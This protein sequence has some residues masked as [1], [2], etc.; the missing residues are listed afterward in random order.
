[1]FTGGAG[2]DT[3]NGGAGNDTYLFDTDSALGF[4]TLTEALGGGTDVLDFNGSSNSVT[5]N[6]GTTGSQTVNSNLTLNLS[7][8]QAENLTGGS[9]N[10]TLTGNGQDNLLSGGAGDDTLNGGDGN[11]MLN[12][13]DGNDILDGGNGNDSLNSGAGNDAITTGPGVDMID[14]GTDDDLIIVTGSHDAG[15]AA[16]GGSGT[17]IFRFDSGTTGILQLISN[18][19]DTLDFSLFGTPVTIDLSE[20]SQ[21]DVGGGLLLT[22]SGWFEHVIGSVFDDTIT[23]NDADNTLSGGDG[24]DTLDGGSGSDT[25]NGDAG[26]D[27]LDGGPGTDTLDGGTDTDTVKNYEAADTHLNIEK[28]IPTP[29]T[30]GGATPHKSS[31]SIIPGPYGTAVLLGC[32]TNPVYLGTQDNGLAVFYNLC[33]YSV[34]LEKIKNTMDLPGDAEF[35]DGLTITLMHGTET[36]DV[37][38]QGTKVELKFALPSVPGKSITAYHWDAMGENGNGAWVLTPVELTDG[39]AMITV[40]TSGVYVLAVQ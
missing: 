19:E 1:V 28:G 11:D 10:D 15:D 23:G 14:G 33:G 24:N 8:S 21:Q 17:N 27:L 2:N 22:L 13:S 37:L 9:G 20:D 29:S 18:G 35:L 26:D 25:L 40:E 38:P 31:P 4:D 5:V 39:Q 32:D 6:L 16:D 30:T 3:L 7:A 34:I 12:G 36:V